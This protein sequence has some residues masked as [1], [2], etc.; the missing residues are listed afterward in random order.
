M[1]LLGEQ[2]ASDIVG[3][4][5][6]KEVQALSDLAM[7]GANDVSQEAVDRVLD[8]FISELKKQT[9]LAWGHP[10]TLKAFSQSL[11]A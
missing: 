1:L 9:N 5:E 11:G 4:L 10:T 8:E 7:V 2:Q 6:L 3:Y